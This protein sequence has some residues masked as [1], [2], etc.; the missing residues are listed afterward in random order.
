MT[1]KELW[2][3]NQDEKYLLCVNEG[4]TMTGIS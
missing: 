3:D 1:Q 4:D 2:R